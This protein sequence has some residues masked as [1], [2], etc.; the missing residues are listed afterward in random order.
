MR[1]T[2]Y[3]SLSLEPFLALFDNRRTEHVEALGLLTVTARDEIGT[4]HGLGPYENILCVANL[5]E[6]AG[7]KERGPAAKCARLAACF[8]PYQKLTPSTR[9]LQGCASLWF[10]IGTR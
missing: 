6:V 4:A 5:H 2:L 8:S 1:I 3:I 7:V 10:G 9:I